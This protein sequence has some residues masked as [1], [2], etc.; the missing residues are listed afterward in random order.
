MD[1]DSDQRKQISAQRQVL[2]LEKE[3]GGL[4]SSTA[5]E[6]KSNQP[7]QLG[8]TSAGTADTEIKQVKGMLP[9]GFFDNKDADLRARGIKPVKPDVK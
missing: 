9:E 6:S 2:N 8:Q 3:K 7:K 5:A 1:P 4:P